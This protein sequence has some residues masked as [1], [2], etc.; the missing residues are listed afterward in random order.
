MEEVQEIFR[1]MGVSFIHV[2]REANV[3]VDG[4]AKEG[5]FRSSLF[6]DL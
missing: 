2:L 3:I 1:Q 6:F 4:L 5:V